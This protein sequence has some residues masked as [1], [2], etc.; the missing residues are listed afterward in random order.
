MWVGLFFG[1]EVKKKNNKPEL[2]RELKAAE[3]FSLFSLTEMI[4][5]SLGLIMQHC[6][7][8]EP[9]LQVSITDFPTH[10]IFSRRALIDLMFVLSR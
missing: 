4:F 1:M 9:G 3:I 5:F 7:L 2:R 6:C 10:L 8:K